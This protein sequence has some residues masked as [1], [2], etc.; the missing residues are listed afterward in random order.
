MFQYFF[1]K[2]ENS[3]PLHIAC[4][5]SFYEIVILLLNHPNIN[6]SP[7]DNVSFLP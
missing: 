6:I 3:T 2:V 5:N 7:I 4:K 1:F